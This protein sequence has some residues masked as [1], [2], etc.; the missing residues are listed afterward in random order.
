M[1]LTADYEKV[2]GI[3]ASPVLDVG[4]S[5][6]NTKT[7]THKGVIDTGASITMIPPS[8]V[9]ALALKSV[10]DVMLAGIYGAQR[11]RTY[12]ID[13]SVDGTVFQ[14]ILA[15]VFDK[16]A[17]ILIGRNVIN[18]WDLRLCGRM[19]KLVLEPWS[20]NG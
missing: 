19:R 7:A 18:L 17:R 16:E 4:V 15:A 13:L 2:A 14:E 1:R 11:S 6:R 8:V 9:D 20:T 3:P 5:S 12:R 10:G